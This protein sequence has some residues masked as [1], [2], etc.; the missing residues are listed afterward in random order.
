MAIDRAELAW[1]Q[2]SQVILHYGRQYYLTVANKLHPVLSGFI[3][4]DLQFEVSWAEKNR[5]QEVSIFRQ[6]AAS[7]RHNRYG[8]SE[9]QFCLQIPPQWG[10]F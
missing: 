6:T 8:C 5:G 7:F 2:V 3:V 4:S 1:S 9:F 10:H